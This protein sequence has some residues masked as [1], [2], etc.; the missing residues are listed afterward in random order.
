[1]RRE[2]LRVDKSIHGQPDNK[3]RTS[4]FGPALAAV[5]AGAPSLWDDVVF[6]YDLI[7]EYLTPS[8]RAV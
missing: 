6:Y 7:R 4:R 1:M 3:R 8:R 2:S 5:L